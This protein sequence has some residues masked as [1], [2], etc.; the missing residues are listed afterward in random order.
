MAKEVEDLVKV[1]DVVASRKGKKSWHRRKCAGARWKYSLFLKLIKPENEIVTLFR[2]K[3][4][5][6]PLTYDDNADH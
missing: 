1:V 6:R 5:C 4:L 2:I 3:A